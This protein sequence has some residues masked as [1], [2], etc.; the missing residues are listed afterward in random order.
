[1][2][3]T[4]LVTLEATPTDRA[5]IEHIKKLAKF[6]NSRVVLLHVATVPWPN[7]A[8]RTRPA[9]RS[10]RDRRTWTSVRAEFEA[11]WRPGRG[12]TCLRHAAGQ[13]NRQVG[14]GK[15]LRPRGHEHARAPFAGRLV[16]RSDRY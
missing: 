15:R 13:A 14:P 16:A 7:G 5:I 1:M 10:R 3:E 11:I 8:A 12:A 6:M 4:I 9:R 2:Y